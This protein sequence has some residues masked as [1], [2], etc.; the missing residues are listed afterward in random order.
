MTRRR[1][2][3]V[4]KDGPFSFADALEALTKRRDSRL[5]ISIREFAECR[6]DNLC[7][8]ARKVVFYVLLA[9]YRDERGS[10]LGYVVRSVRRPFAVLVEWQVVAFEAFSQIHHLAVSL[11]CDVHVRWR[12][13]S[14]TARPKPTAGWRISWRGNVA[15]QGVYLAL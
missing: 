1:M 11:L 7:V 13:D 14:W 8:S 3:L 2:R 6:L 12:D 10:F 5:S 15:L 9:Q 4:L